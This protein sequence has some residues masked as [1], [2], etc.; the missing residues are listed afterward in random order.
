MAYDFFKA[1]EKEFNK[2][3]RIM[4]EAFPESQIRSRVKMYEILTQHDNYSI[5]CVG[6]VGRL[7]K[8]VIGFI[9][10]WEL[11]DIV[12]FENLAIEKHMRGK[13]LRS[14]LL[15]LVVNTTTKPIVFEIEPP[16]TFAQKRRIKFYQKHKMIFNDYNYVMPP[17]KKDDE[18]TPLKLM[19]YPRALT[20]KE[21]EDAKDNIHKEVYNYQDGENLEIIY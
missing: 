6:S 1:S 11:D 16:E 14:L 21:F 17:L 5:H 4:E 20:P 10:V 18:F 8:N 13:S 15:E 2:V 7:D 19:S 12:F 9:V 3:Y